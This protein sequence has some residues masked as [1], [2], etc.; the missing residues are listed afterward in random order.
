MY[1]RIVHSIALYCRFIMCI[2][3]QPFRLICQYCKVQ[4]TLQYMYVQYSKCIVQACK[5]QEC[6]STDVIPCMQHCMIICTV[7]VNSC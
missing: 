5:F 6:I 4:Y 7:T 2:G 1:H 3:H